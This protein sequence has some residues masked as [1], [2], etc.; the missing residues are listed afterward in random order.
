MSAAVIAAGLGAAADILGG[1]SARSAQRRANA[2][3]VKLQRENQA[4][5]E[6][7]SNTSWQ[8]GTKDM[9]AAG[10]NPMLAY[11]QGGASTPNTSAA[12]VEPE[13]AMGRAVSSAGSKAAQAVTLA[14]LQAQ[15]ALTTEKAKQEHMVTNDMEKDRS[16]VTVTDEE[17]TT[18]GG[19]GPVERRRRLET[20]QAQ[21]AETNLSVRKIE[22]RIIEQ[23]EDAAVSS[24]KD[25]ARIL[26]KEVTLA[27][28]RTILMRLDIPEK[29][30]MAK[31][32]QTV[33]AA[34]PAAK[35]AMSIAQW[36]KFM[37]GR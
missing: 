8:R 31:W 15:T 2:L 20:A 11:S 28:L 19:M 30:A 16:T 13:D 25:R 37:F 7:M 18:V 9:L 21:L 23:T 35:A 10:L 3:N 24:A 33:G 1:F 32:F 27:E 17:G 5:E 36:L 4:W 14:N 12:T 26:D 29:E 6:K 34:S 22:Q